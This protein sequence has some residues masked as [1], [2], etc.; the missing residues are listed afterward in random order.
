MASEQPGFLCAQRRRARECEARMT[1]DQLDAAVGKS[2]D[3]RPFPVLPQC[4]EMI[5]EIAQMAIGS[6]RAPAVPVAQRVEM[7]V[8]RE[9]PRLVVEAL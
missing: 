2:P 9:R 5:L 3:A 8:A 1:Q 4:L 6:Q 7:L